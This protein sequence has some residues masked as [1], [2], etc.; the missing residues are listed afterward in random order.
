[1]RKNPR[2]I[3]S[4]QRLP[5]RHPGAGTANLTNNS[6]YCNTAISSAG[7]SKTLGVGSGIS[8]ALCRSVQPHHGRHHML[9][10]QLRVSHNQDRVRACQE[11]RSIMSA[12]YRYE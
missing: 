7:R 10:S 6:S 4:P 1:M 3:L 8:W 11:T 5:F 12:W 9:R 2:R